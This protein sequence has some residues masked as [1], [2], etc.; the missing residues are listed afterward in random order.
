M[1]D[2]FIPDVDDVLRIHQR[3][4]AR[5]G[6]AD[7]LRDRE[8]VA[9]AIGRAEHLIAYG[10]PIVVDLAAAVSA[11]LIRRHCFV[12]GNKRVGFGVLHLMLRAH[13]LHFDVSER[14]A[15][16][17]VLAFAAGELDED[18]YRDWVAANVVVLTD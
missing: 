18:A 12:D 4:I 3:Q 15:V 10:E 8:G 7:G 1:T 11:S 2:V 6:G 16:S 13:D 17:T 5:F 9:A 14:D